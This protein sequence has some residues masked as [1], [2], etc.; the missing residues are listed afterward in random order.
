MIIVFNNKIIMF[1]NNKILMIQYNYIIIIKIIIFNNMGLM[2]RIFQN[3]HHQK[4]TLIYLGNRRINFS[5]LKYLNNIK[6]QKK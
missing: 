6:R 2:G 1:I 4:I 3:F 5:Q